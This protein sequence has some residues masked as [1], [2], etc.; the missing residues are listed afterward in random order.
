MAYEYDFI[1]PKKIVCNQQFRI[2]LVSDDTKLLRK[3]YYVFKKQE[4]VIDITNNKN[5]CIEKCNN[6]K[7]DII[8]IDGD[9]IDINELVILLK[10]TLFIKSHIFIISENEHRKNLII[11]GVLLKSFNL[12]KIIRFI[13]LQQKNNS[14]VMPQIK[15]LYLR[16]KNVF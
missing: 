9:I 8:L 12:N 16:K 14:L 5:E 11:D 1:K 3:L 2:L 15:F 7:Y 13:E 6:K 10:N 4:H